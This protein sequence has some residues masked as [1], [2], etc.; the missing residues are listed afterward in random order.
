[1]NERQIF[2]R[3]FGQGCILS[4]IHIYGAS[5]LDM[6][7]R[8]GIGVAMGNAVPETKAAADYVTTASVDDGICHA[9]E[10]L[11]LI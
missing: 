11:G 10:E 4:L 7:K 8:A 5:D 3:G 6:I 9:L 2:V 1:M